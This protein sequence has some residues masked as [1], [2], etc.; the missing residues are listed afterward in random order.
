R[1]LVTGVAGVIGSHLAER[2][3]AD[4]HS[5]LGVDSFTPGYAPARKEAN[6][7]SIRAHPRFRLARAGLAAAPV[8]RLSAWLADSPYVSHQAAWAGV[9]G[10]WAESFEAYLRSNVLGTQRLL[11]AA[12]EAGVRRFVYAS[13]SSVYGPGLPL[14]LLESGPA[15]PVSPYGATKL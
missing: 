5:V 10:S 4:G 11:E 3:L 14:P 2:L 13:S 9:R 7:A 1:A 6:L 15:R 8:A 12:K